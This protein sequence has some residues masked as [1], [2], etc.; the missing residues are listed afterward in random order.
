MMVSGN[1]TLCQIVKG[2]WK[3]FSAAYSFLHLH[4]LKL[5]PEPSSRGIYE[6]TEYALWLDERETLFGNFYSHNPDSGPVAKQSHIYERRKHDA[7]LDEY[8]LE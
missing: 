7:I 3:D 5:L 8:H 1:L 4:G 2:L 6:F